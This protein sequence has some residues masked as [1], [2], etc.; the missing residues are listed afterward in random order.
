[1]NW[2]HLYARSDLTN[3]NGNDQHFIISLRFARAGAALG[4]RESEFWERDR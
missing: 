3:I 4:F 2:T 1:M